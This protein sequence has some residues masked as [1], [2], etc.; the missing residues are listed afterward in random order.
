MSEV[1]CIECRHS[2]HHCL[3]TYK[4]RAFPITED[5]STDYVTGR[6]CTN[7]IGYQRCSDINYKGTCLAYEPETS[8]WRLFWK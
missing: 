3:G 1:I 4:C 8:K 7:I 2:M 6:I 5:G